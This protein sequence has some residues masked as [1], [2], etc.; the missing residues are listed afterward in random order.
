MLPNSYNANTEMKLSRNTDGSKYYTLGL[1]RNPKQNT[2]M[3]S[4]V[5]SAKI[6]LQLNK[7]HGNVEHTIK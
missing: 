1:F 6:P 4:V 7:E 3:D 2:L 5:T